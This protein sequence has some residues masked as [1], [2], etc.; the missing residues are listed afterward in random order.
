MLSLQA[1]FIHSFHSL[2]AD[3]LECVLRRALPQ[4]L[5]QKKTCRAWRKTED[6]MS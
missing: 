4:V 6:L 2:T 3:S 5:I 1:E